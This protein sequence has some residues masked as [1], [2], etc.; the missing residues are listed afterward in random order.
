[1][2]LEAVASAL[3]AMAE[4]D[5]RVRHELARDGSLFDGY[6]PRMREVHDR[7]A[8]ALTEILDRVGW[9]A[10]SLVGERAARA[11]WVVLQHAIGHPL[12]QRRGLALLRALPSHERDPVEVASLEDRIRAFEGR[13]QLYGT[14]FDWDENGEL[15]P[16]PIEAPEAVDERR[17][18]VGLQPLATTVERQRAAALAEGERP[19]ADRAR[20]RREFERWLREVGW[21]T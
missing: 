9:P 7:N 20:R 14:Q 3:I 15:S 16:F 19:P 11:A 5:A 1:M 10:P 8:A 12:L 18:T 17:A 4:E 21:R 13:G 6:H 2:D